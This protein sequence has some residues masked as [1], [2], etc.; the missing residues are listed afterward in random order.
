MSPGTSGLAEGP[1]TLAPL[2]NLA[3][4]TSTASPADARLPVAGCYL[5]NYTPTG[6]SNFI[7]DGTLRVEA[8]TGRLRASGDLYERTLSASGDFPPPPDP[9]LG[10]P[11]L[12][13]DGYRFYLDVSEIAATSDA[14]S[15]VFEVSRF[16]VGGT[17]LFD[18]RATQWPKDGDFSARMTAN[19]DAAGFPAPERCYVGDVTNAAGKTVGRISMGWVSPYLR[20]AT[21]E[22]DRVAESEVPVGN[23]V[24]VTWRTI[25]DKLGWDVTVSVSDDDVMV[26][27]GG[28]AWTKEEATGAMLARRDKSDLD[29]EWR[30]HILAVKQIDFPDGERGVMYDQGGPWP[31]R[32]PREGLMVASHWVFPD[33][34][35]WGLVKGMRTGTTVTYFRTAVHEL[36]HAM[37]L[38]HNEV[39][40]AFMSPT[41]EIAK[42]ASTTPATP[43]P[44][45]IE[46]SFSPEDQHR[47]RHWPDLIV[48]PGGLNAGAGKSAPIAAL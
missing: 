25:F 1:R 28:R 2:Q 33:Q 32:F 40:N 14:F 18:A 37:G 42:H 11:S 26:A 29:A 13:I 8:S 47:L 36:G 15:L 12:P 43:F 48:R 17:R 10:I 30:Y 3:L 27:N 4:A 44:T 45:N 38:D 34:D 39:G 24:G 41:T 23:G 9:A 35:P 21:V 5:L 6:D 19:P 46:W 20:K 16:G 31:N 22:I 7:L